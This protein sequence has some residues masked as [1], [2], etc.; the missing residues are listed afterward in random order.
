MFSQ[1]CVCP[2]GG[3]GTQAEPLPP[4]LPG[5]DRIPLPPPGQDQDSFVAGGMPLAFTQEDIL[6]FLL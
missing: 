4:L 3:G 2:R 6:A 1:V 5:Q